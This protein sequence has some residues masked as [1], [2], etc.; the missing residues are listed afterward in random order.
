MP[1]TKNEL[2]LPIND[3]ER[4]EDPDGHWR[5]YSNVILEAKFRP[6]YRLVD[7]WLMLA[8]P[9]FDCVF[10]WRQ[11]Q[12]RKL[13]ATLPSNQAGK[14]M[15]DTALQRFI[16]HYE[17]ITRQCLRILPDRVNHLYKLNEQRVV[18]AYRHRQQSD[19][20]P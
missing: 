9:S 19:M 8:A 6:L 17:R 13:A 20:L 18:T 12:E 11:E 3:L 14:L 10:E 4:N 7:Q 5:G 15:N 1:Q 16:Q 2:S